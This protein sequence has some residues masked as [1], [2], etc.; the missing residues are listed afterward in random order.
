MQKQARVNNVAALS[1]WKKKR[2]ENH[3][4]ADSKNVIVNNSFSL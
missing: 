1:Y 2:E 4:K 3:P